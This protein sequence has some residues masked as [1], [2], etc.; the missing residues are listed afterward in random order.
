MYLLLYSYALIS[1]SSYIR[2]GIWSKESAHS[3]LRVYLLS[4]QYRLLTINIR[5]IIL[6][7]VP[8]CHIIVPGGMASIRLPLS[9]ALSRYSACRSAA[10]QIPPHRGQ[11]IFMSPRRIDLVFLVS[12]K[13]IIDTIFSVYSTPATLG[14]YILIIYISPLYIQIAITIISGLTSYYIHKARPIS[15]LTIKYI[16]IAAFGLYRS[17]NPQGQYIN[18][19]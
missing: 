17:W 4:L 19:I 2:I 6:L 14:L 8:R 9:T 12:S 11:W 7:A 5:L 16:Y 3:S 10:I 18:Y 1:R 13:L 15:L